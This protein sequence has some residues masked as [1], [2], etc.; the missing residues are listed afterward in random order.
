MA[1]AVKK[2][3]SVP[4]MAVGRINDP[5]VAEDILQKDEADLVVMGRA[6]L[7]DPDLPNKSAEGR[8]EDIAPCIA[9]GLGCSGRKFG[10]ELTIYVENR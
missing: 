10:N 9:C 3:V 7:A 6:F 4:V 8:F 2:V 5:R 1:S